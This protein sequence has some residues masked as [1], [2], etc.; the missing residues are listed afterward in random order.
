MKVTRWFA[1]ALVVALVV[2]LWASPSDAAAKRWAPLQMSW[3]GKVWATHL[4]KSLF[5]HTTLIPGQTL[6]RGFYVR[7]H[8]HDNAT[9]LVKVELND[10]QKLAASKQFRLA[11][12]HHGHWMRVTATGARGARFVIPQGG[13]DQIQVRATYLK[14]ATN[15]TQLRTFDF[16]LQLRLTQRRG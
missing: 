1:T 13:T 6:T 16:K 11:V 9:L 15:A 12:G 5:R 8:S 7:N 3:Q 10:P 14:T 4:H 2:G